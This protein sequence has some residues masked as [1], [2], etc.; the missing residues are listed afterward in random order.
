MQFELTEDQKMI[1]K[2]AR[3]FA[4]QRLAPGVQ[5][6]GEKHFFDR[7]TECGGNAV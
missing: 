2:M 4:E 3:E 7:N 6:R 1:Q 5:E